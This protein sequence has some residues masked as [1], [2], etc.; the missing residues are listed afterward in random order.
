MKLA[1][2]NIAWETKDDSAVYDYLCQHNF[3]AIEIAPTR[4]FP[5]QPYEH[6]EQAGAFKDQLWKDYQLSIC[7]IQSIWFGKKEQLFLGSD[8]DYETLLEYTKQAIQFASKVG[9]KNIVFGSP[10]NRLIDDRVS[11]KQILLFFETIATYALLHDT[12]IGL[13]ANPMIYGTNFLNTTQEA[14]DFCEELSHSG[15]KLN[16]DLGTCILNDESLEVIAEALPYVQHVHI[17]EP[18]LKPIKWSQL[19]SKLASLLYQAEY[20]GYVS[21]EMASGVMREEL[22]VII[23]EMERIFADE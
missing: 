16:L 13:E 10:K 20:K 15:L 11:R 17:S 12:V 19:H 1:I 5:A 8:I 21:I 14:V 22:F 2:S 23:S 4:L 9:A 18:Y 7:S 6:L 3:S